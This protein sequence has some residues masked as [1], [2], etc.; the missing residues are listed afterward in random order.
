MINLQAITFI[1]KKNIPSLKIMLD[2]SISLC[3]NKYIIRERLIGN[4]TR[5]LLAVEGK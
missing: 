3:Y 4:A 1:F 5:Q 2:K